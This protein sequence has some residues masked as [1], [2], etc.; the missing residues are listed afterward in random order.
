LLRIT[1]ATLQAATVEV[2]ASVE[3][4]KPLALLLAI[5]ARGTSQLR[6]PVLSPDH[7][8]RVLFQLGARVEESAGQLTLRGQPALPGRSLKVPPD[9]SA[10]APLIVVSAVTP[11]AQLRVPMVGYNP[12]RAAL[13]R[14]LARLGCRLERERDWQFG[15]EPVTALRVEGTSRLHAGQVA[16]NAAGALLGEFLLLALACTQAR[17]N[18]R[19]RGAGVLRQTL[20]D[21]LALAAEMLRA[22]GADVELLPDGLSLS[23]PTVLHG[24][25]VNAADDPDLGRVALG[26]ALLAGGPSELHG[27]GGVEACYPGLVSWLRHGSS[28]AGESNV[29]NMT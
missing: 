23:G 8:E 13:L 3:P 10:A 18:S 1:P 29:A 21:R 2:P 16:P 27:M 24:A 17:G 4:L 6:L 25:E 22:F 5:G 28:A 9:F 15:S 14:S 11:G 12:S 26:L 20:P 7:L 19:L